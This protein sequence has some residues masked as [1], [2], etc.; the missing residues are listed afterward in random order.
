M[1]EKEEKECSGCE[2]RKTQPKRKD[3]II[4]LN[5]SFVG[6]S[7]GEFECVC[8]QICHPDQIDVSAVPEISP[9]GDSINM[10]E[11]KGV[12]TCVE[13]LRMCSEGGAWCNFWF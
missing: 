10:S 5:Q 9:R 11:D 13:V 2:I 1:R 8:E 3:P 6:N 4:S 7:G 12:V